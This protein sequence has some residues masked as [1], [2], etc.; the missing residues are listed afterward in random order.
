MAEMNLAPVSY[1]DKDMATILKGMVDQIPNLTNRWTD[2]SPSDVGM[3]ILELL[4]WNLQML[5]FY[6]DRQANEA[7]LSTSRE[8][9]NVVNLCKLI[10]YKLAGV[11]S[12]TANVVISL[13]SPIS[14]RVEIPKYTVLLTGEEDVV[15]FATM[16][17]AVIPPGDTEVT[18]G[19][20]QGIPKIEKHKTSGDRNQKFRVS[21]SR[22]D[23]DSFEVVINGEIWQQVENFVNS[24]ANDKH[25][26]V[27]IDFDGNVDV[28]LG[29]NFFGYSPPNSIIENVV[30]T[31]LIS[32]GQNG[33]VGGDAIK[34]LVGNFYDSNFPSPNQISLSVTSSSAATGGSEQE[35]IEHAKRQAP[36]ELSAL[37]RAMTRADFEA[38][39]NGYEGVSKS[40]AWGEQDVNP[41]NY[42]MFNWVMVAIAPDNITRDMLIEDD[43]VN[44]LP[45]NELKTNLLNY[46]YSRAT[47]TTRIKLVDPSY[48]GVSIA[49]NVFYN[50]KAQAS[51]VK[52]DIDTALNNFFSFDNVQFGKEIRKSN[53]IRLIDSVSGVDY[54]EITQFKRD[55]SIVDVEDAIVI[56]MNELPYLKVSAITAEKTSSAPPT[57]TIYPFPPAPPIPVD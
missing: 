17:S 37:F 48:V 46:L 20:R 24:Q 19:V 3:V 27:N 57:P 39:A 23:K 9:K 47:I 21:E 16:S 7:F 31:Y 14:T 1:T 41:P 5:A 18:I 26:T 22:A 36:A 43:L 15:S 50:P 33:N 34:T 4:S 28:T 8:R 44:G 54:V 40:I 11:T 45:S 10:A 29:D 38:L 56:L 53:I 32:D 25:Y 6:M 55:T 2:F 30:I 52:S 49:A 42:N 35:T 51:V 12:S 13:E